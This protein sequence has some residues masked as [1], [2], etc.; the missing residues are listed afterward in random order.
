MLA[1][2]IG[3]TSITLTGAF[4]LVS[5]AMYEVQLAAFEDSLRLV[6]DAEAEWIGA[7]DEVAVSD[8]PGPVANDVGPLA[9][10]AVVYDG[11]GRVLASTFLGPAPVRP[12][13]TEDG[14]FFDVWDQG[15]RLRGLLLPVAGRPGFAVLVAAPRTDIDGDRRLLGQAMLGAF[16]VALVSATVMSIWIV[17]RV[18]RRQARIAT[19]ARRVAAGDLAA[20]IGAHAGAPEEVQLARDVDGMIDRLERLVTSQRRFIAHAAHEL[21]SPLTTLYGEISHALRRPRDAE[22][23]REAIAS[24]LVSARELRDLAEDLLTLVRI[25]VDRRK[26]S[27]VFPLERCVAAVVAQLSGVAEAAGVKIE[28]VGRAHPVRGRERDI[29]RMLRNLLENAVRYSPAGGRIELRVVDRGAAVTLEV[30]DAGPGVD[31]ADRERIFEP[32]Q[33]GTE[34]AAAAGSGCGLGLT[35]AREIAAAHGGTLEIVDPEPPWSACFRAT[36]KGSWQDE[37]VGPEAA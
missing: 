27:E 4:A 5:V 3:V 33:R 21:R 29:G 28:T 19:V 22:G 12:T 2:V 9:K 1:I 34:R 18:T 7:R 25:G 32:F 37:G 14:G 23:Y 26:D 24:A 20:R 11:D 15:E 17:R 35:I 31:P 10:F 36:L 8:L 6:A 16:V 30:L 13:E